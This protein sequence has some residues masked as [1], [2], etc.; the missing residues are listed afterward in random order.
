MKKNVLLITPMLHQGGFERI[1]VQTARLLEQDYNITI[2]IFSDRDAF[3]DVTGL[4]VVNLDIPSVQGRAGKAVNVL[5]RVR[6]LKK[7]KRERHIDISYSFGQT[8]NLANTLS[9]T[10]ERVYC[11]IHSYLDLGEPRAIRLYLKKADR[12]ACCSEAIE[13]ELKTKYGAR[14]TFTL[15]NPIRLPEPGKT[16]PIDSDETD[17][18]GPE[19][20]GNSAVA[21]NAA[22]GSRKAGSAADAEAAAEEK[23]P[24]EAA[25]L[26]GLAEFLRSHP[27]RI[28]SMGRED[29]VK[30]FWHLLRA[31]AALHRTHPEAGVLILGD[32]SFDEYR[33]QADFLGIGGDVFFTGALADPF[34]VLSLG[35]VYA[36]TSL[37][38]GLPNALLEA[39]GLGLPVIAADCATGPREILEPVPDPHGEA[40]YGILIPVMEEE[41]NLAQKEMTPAEHALAGN[42]KQMIEQ[43]EL[44]QSY[45]R[46]AVIRARDFSEQAYAE[47]LRKDF[48]T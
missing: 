21:Q 41:K 32:G 9:R 16:E 7:L 25:V 46:R 24:P 35:T 45:S 13:Q 37:H 30:G 34:P 10:G 6:A 47:R 28:M 43:P 39:M 11:S 27:V 8:A 44:R 4:D 19:Q 18:A 33:R 15:H 5:R 22:S 1:C 38:E 14:N 12:V 31:A 26:P 2:A 36:L 29:D 20:T 40:P 42:L 3:Y 17:D 48:N 23:Y